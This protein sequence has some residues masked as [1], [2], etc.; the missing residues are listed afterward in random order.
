[1]VTVVVVVTHSYVCVAAGEAAAMMR[2]PAA[3][4]IRMRMRIKGSKGGE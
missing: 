4:M 2:V 1:M 3:R